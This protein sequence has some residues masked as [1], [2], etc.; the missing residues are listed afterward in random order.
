MQSKLQETQKVSR[1]NFW[2]EVFRVVRQLYSLTGFLSN[3]LLWNRLTF[4]LRTGSPSSNC[5]VIVCAITV[6]R[7]NYKISG[8]ILP[9]NRESA[10]VNVILSGVIK[11]V[12]LNFVPAVLRANKKKK[13]VLPRQ[14]TGTFFKRKNHVRLRIVQC[15]FL[16]F[17]TCCLHVYSRGLTTTTQWG[18]TILSLSESCLVKSRRK[19]D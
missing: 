5:E 17:S 9:R 19:N 10:N 12:G 11:S 15:V 14:S 18:D 2:P 6:I 13:T 3:V 4:E 8:G 7:R 1:R 16:R